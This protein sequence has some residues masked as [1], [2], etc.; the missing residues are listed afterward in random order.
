VFWKSD[1][2]REFLPRIFASDASSDFGFGASVAPATIDEVRQIARV[3]EKQG[4]YVMLDGGTEDAKRL[5][6]PHFLNLKKSDFVHILSVKKL[7]AAH[8]NVL[9]GEA[10]ILLLRWILRSCKQHSSR[11]VILVDSSVWLGAAAKGR[12]STALNRLLRKAAALQMAGDLMVLV[13]LV[14]SAENPSDD[15]SRGIRFKRKSGP[16]LKRRK[17]QKPRS[18]LQALLRELKHNYSQWAKIVGL[19][20]GSSDESS[21]TDV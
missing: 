12:S 7:L 5:G 4:D 2:S 17:G 6:Q 13:V 21:D 1:L 18:S 9:E 16:K 10:Y 15:P 19:D 11:V 3:A 20:S 8:I 14:P